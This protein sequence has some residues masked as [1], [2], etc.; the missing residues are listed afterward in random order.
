MDGEIPCTA[1]RAPAGCTGDPAG[2][3]CDTTCA[4]YGGCDG[5]GFDEVTN[6]WT[7]DEAS[8]MACQGGYGSV[9]HDSFKIIN[10]FK[11]TVTGYSFANKCY[12]GTGGTCGASYS[13]NTRVCPCQCG[14]GTYQPSTGIAT[15]CLKYVESLSRTA[16]SD[17]IS[18]TL[19]LC[20]FAMN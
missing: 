5:A 12:Y 3:S 13:T 10:P 11:E 14:V 18:R 1:G 6:H 8:S 20:M 2:I 9:S 19:F 15:T 4:A 16:V 7:F 17:S